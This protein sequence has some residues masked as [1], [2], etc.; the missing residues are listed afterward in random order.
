M[1]EAKCN[2]LAIKSDEEEMMRMRM[3]MDK[4]KAENAKIN[5]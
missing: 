2:E 1:L 5:L 3:E 4:N